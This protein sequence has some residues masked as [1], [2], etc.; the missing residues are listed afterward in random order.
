MSSTTQSALRMIR[1]KGSDAVTRYS[2]GVVEQ[3][4]EEGVKVIVMRRDKRSGKMVEKPVKPRMVHRTDLLG[5]Y[6]DTHEF[7]GE[8]KYISTKAFPSGSQRVM[9][10]QH[11][12]PYL[13]ENGA[14]A[15]IIDAFKST[16]PKKVL[17]GLSAR[18]TSNRLSGIHLLWE[19][20]RNADGFCSNACSEWL[21]AE[22]VW[23]LAREINPDL[24]KILRKS[25]SGRKGVKTHK[26]AQ[27]KFF[28]DLDVLRRATCVVDVSTGDHQFCGGATPY[29]KPLEQCG[30]AIDKR[31]LTYDVDDGD[32]LAQYYYRLVIGRPEPHSLPRSSWVYEGSGSV[33][34]FK[35]DAARRKMR[36]TA[37]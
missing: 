25:K 27:E 36:S 17:N 3:A 26:S 1:G 13:R 14:Y 5:V 22:E 16:I 11:V 32:D 33:V 10:A 6:G 18:T 37:A 30:F 4:R 15:T 9:G 12:N 35:N 34:A 8:G 24:L 7:A 28:G 20:K 2:C 23:T 31:F 21:T 19:G 29:S